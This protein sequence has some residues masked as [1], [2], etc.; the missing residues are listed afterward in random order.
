[1]TDKIENSKLNIQE[2]TEDDIEDVFPIDGFIYL[3]SSSGAGKS[4]LTTWLFYWMRKR[5]HSCIIISPTST[6][7]EDYLQF[8]F[9]ER[10]FHYNLQDYKLKEILKKIEDIQDSIGETYELGNLA[11]IID[12][13]FTSSN[14]AGRWNETLHSFVCLRRHRNIFCVLI[15]QNLTNCSP[16]IRSQCSAMITWVP[17]TIDHREKIKN[18]FLTREYINHNKKETMN[19]ADRI[20]DSIFTVPYRAMIVRTQSPH[21]GMLKN[22]YQILAPEKI[23]KFKLKYKKLKKKKIKEKDPKGQE[24]NITYY[25]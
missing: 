15:S 3:S 12:D 21:L 9:C 18:W 10:Q 19:L 8:E 4:H 16:C 1:M 17:V 23:P 25:I 6:L 24:N 5:F 2:F 7:R 13:M 22:T 11:V 14:S 20:M